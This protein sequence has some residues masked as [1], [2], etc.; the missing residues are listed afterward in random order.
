MICQLSVTILH[1]ITLTSNLLEKLNHLLLINKHLKSVS[2]E[3]I[4]QPILVML[5]TLILQ[6]L[7]V[8]L[9]IQLTPAQI[10]NAPY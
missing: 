10:L 2:L 6:N 7:F 1:V 9:I 8:K 3:K 4:Y 5:A